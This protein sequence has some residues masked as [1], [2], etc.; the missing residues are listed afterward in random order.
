MI[1]P[2]YNEL[3]RRMTHINQIGDSVSVIEC[4]LKVYKALEPGLLESTYQ[5]CLALELEEAGL[6]IIREGALHVVYKYVHLQ[7]AYRI[8]QWVKRKVI[9]ENQSSVAL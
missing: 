3:K 6:K 1:G 2:S 4:A 9:L 7:Q 8:N 5:S